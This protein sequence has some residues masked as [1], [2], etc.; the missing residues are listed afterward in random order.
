MS[1]VER[2][3]GLHWRGQVPALLIGLGHGATHWI[4]ATFYLLL[5]FIARHFDLS[6]AE[7]GVLVAL[8]HLSSV[9]ANFLSGLIVDVTGRRVVFQVISLTAGAAALAGFVVANDY[10]QLGLFILVIGATNN[11]WHPPAIAF[12][13]Q[14]YPNNRG[15]AL[16]IHALGANAGDA[17][18][19]LAAGALLV[20]FSWGATAALSALPA[21]AMAVVLALVL[22]ARDKPGDGTARVG[23]TMTDYFRGFARVL[24]DKTVLGL[25]LMA[26]FRTMTQAGLLAFLPLYLADV[27]RLGPLWMGLALSIM[28][29]TGIVAAPLAGTWSDRI[30]RRPVVLA[31]LTGATVMLAGL[32]L[33]ADGP[34]FVVGIA[35]LGFALFAIRP[36]V[37]SWL[38]DLTPPQLAGSASSLMFGVQA[39]LSALVPLIGG[40]LADA[41]GLNAVF[42]FL[43]GTM[44]VANLLVVALPH[45]DRAGAGA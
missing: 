4:A 38:M 37:H 26:G 45:R 11:L 6:Y 29:L 35:L 42:Y 12:L 39:A 43:A 25:C 21:L 28:Q 8:F 36:V 20:W 5:P 41:W 32:T 33:I 2:L 14:L 31:G 17:A 10:W 30:G 19:P 16:S 9:A 18:A 24:R 22:L 34:L 40:V 1:T 44:L 23:M 7:V 3:T 27:L 15:Y 13:S